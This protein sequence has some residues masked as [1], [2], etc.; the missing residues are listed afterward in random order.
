MSWCQVLTFVQRR[1]LAM[2]KLGGTLL[3]CL[4]A[5]VALADCAITGS[6]TASFGNIN[7][8]DIA[9]AAKTLAV[10]DSGLRCGA[11]TLLGLLADDIAE[12]TIT[13]SGN[14]QL[15]NAA[16]GDRIPYQVFADPTFTQQLTFGTKYD[17]YNSYILSLL[18]ILTVG[19]GNNTFPMYFR[20]V[21][22]GLNVSAGTYTD[23]LTVNWNWYVCVVKL[24]SLCIGRSTGTSSVTITVNLTILN[25]CV[26]IAPTLNF[27]SAPLVSGFQPVGNTIDIRCTKNS[28]YNVG[29]SDGSNAS[30]GQ[31]R[32]KSGSNF[33][34]YEIYKGT[35]AGSRWGS[36]GA[37]RRSS[38]TADTN[39]AAYNGITGQGFKYHAVIPS[40]STPPAGVYTDTIIVDV[41]F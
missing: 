24:G 22:A 28:A 35:S 19:S 32:M 4:L 23:T 31:R 25:D 13:S 36:A 38:A 9:S 39:P 6:S 26:I 8:L 11:P 40:Q 1:T 7:S 34:N 41:Q 37:E 12:A 20:T 17:Y 27:G 2:V 10:N 15:V 3:V 16:S 14:S 5:N 18:G 21:P 33:L 30:G 29:L